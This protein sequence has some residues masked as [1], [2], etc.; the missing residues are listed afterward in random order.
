MSSP[1]LS[2]YPDSYSGFY[3]PRTG[4]PLTLPQADEQLSIVDMAKQLKDNFGTL[5]KHYLKT[6]SQLQQTL[7]HHD[8]Q[9]GYL[10]L[11]DEPVKSDFYCSLESLVF[12]S[13][14]ADSLAS[15][16]EK[17][18]LT[19]TLKKTILPLSQWIDV[20]LKNL[21]KAHKLHQKHQNFDWLSSPNEA[22]I[23]QKGSSVA[24][25]TDT[26]QLDKNT[27]GVIGEAKHHFKGSEMDL[28]MLTASR[29]H[30]LTQQFL[31]SGTAGSISFLTLAASNPY[32]PLPYAIAVEAVGLLGTQFA[33]LFLARRNGG[34]L[35]QQAPSDFESIK[36][37]L[38]P[39]QV[40]VRSQ[41][42][43]QFVDH[44]KQTV[45]LPSYEKLLNSTA[46]DLSTKVRTSFR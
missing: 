3:S 27:H 33:Q 14:G 11:A 45:L 19:Q 12:L 24:E 8:N 38:H 17:N 13:A 29:Q 18:E 46:D 1:N 5:E 4:K 31:L 7:R 34:A 10:C 36:I 42:L 23:N 6:K 21:K 35:R 25:T 15:S 30:V 40:Q 32:S 22:P 9:M 43:S 16:P 41:A 39:N 37:A 28:T 2:L 26:P 44:I 20:H